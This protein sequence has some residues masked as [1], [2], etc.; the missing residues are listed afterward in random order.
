[1]A[2]D[3]T[4]KSGTIHTSQGEPPNSRSKPTPKGR[5]VAAKPI[6]KGKLVKPGAPGGGPSKLSS[7][8]KP[9]Q[10]PRTVPQPAVSQ[11]KAPIPAAAQPRP[12]PQPATSQPKSAPQPA[13]GIAA[14]L[15]GSNLGRSEPTTSTVRAPP[16]PPPPAAAPKDAQP[17][18]KAVYEFNGQSQNEMSLKKDELII[19]QNK[20]GNGWWLAKRKDGSASGW[21]PSAYIEE[22]KPAPAPPPPPPAPAA[23]PVPTPATNGVRAKPTPPA[24][25]TKRPAA[26]SNKPAPPPAPRD[27]GYSGGNSNAG[28][29]TNTPR[30]SGG[31]L[32]GGLADALRQRQA[33]MNGRKDNN[34]E[35]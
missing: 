4:Y 32:A 5:Q 13:A 26:R 20:E 3:D 10:Q 12:V 35:W 16:P 1:M 18:F 15:S 30:E 6:N 19:I 21:V 9:Q 2:R 27:S 8:P 24:P 23:R 33:A 22:V 11:L 29:G 34:D 17:T 7:R 28:T 14:A 25:P 31:S